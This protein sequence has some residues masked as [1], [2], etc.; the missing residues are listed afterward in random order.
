[1]ST[2]SKLETP[3][4]QEETAILLEEYERRIATLQESLKQAGRIHPNEAVILQ[5]IKRV[6]EERDDMK[7]RLENAEMLIER[8]K[9]DNK[10]FKFDL[11]LYNNAD[12][13]ALALWRE[14]H[15]D[16]SE[17]FVP[18]LG[19]MLM[20][21]MEQIDNANA[22]QPEGTTKRDKALQ[23]I[24]VVKRV[25]VENS[26]PSEFGLEDCEFNPETGCTLCC[27]DCWNEEVGEV[28]KAE[29]AI[30]TAVVD[31]ERYCHSEYGSENCKWEPGIGCT[32]K[33]PECIP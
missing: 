1:M 8:L 15:P 30:R 23:N 32:P 12:A 11:D 19:K 4:G 27:E 3:T 10:Q 16:T 5:E 26:C 13:K 7:R 28:E 22:K 18:G 24:E 2:I 9:E 25:L 14:N 33:C 21:L 6:V 17:C 29:T 20:W 31:G